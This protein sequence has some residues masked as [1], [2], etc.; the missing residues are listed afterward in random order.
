MLWNSLH[1][2][3]W[4]CKK[5]Q[6]VQCTTNIFHLMNGGGYLPNFVHLKHAR[7]IRI[8]SCPLLLNEPLVRSKN[9]LQHFFIFRLLI[10]GETIGNCEVYFSYLHFCFISSIILQPHWYGCSQYSEWAFE[11]YLQFHLSLHSQ[12]SD[13]VGQPVG[14]KAEWYFKVPRKNLID[15]FFPFKSYH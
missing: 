13:T 7:R 15:F 9:T 12:R 14:A 8:Q 1:I 10:S 4:V 5:R 6:R 2:V 11:Q 3:P